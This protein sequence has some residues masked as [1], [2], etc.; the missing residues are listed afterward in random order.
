MRYSEETSEE[1]AA[2]AAASFTVTR[3]GRGSIVLSGACPRCSSSMVFPTVDRLYRS[4]APETEAKPILVFCTATDQEYEG[5]PKGRVGCGAYWNL[6][7]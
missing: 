7:L 4:A 5:Q 6:V 2:R 3:P 1:F